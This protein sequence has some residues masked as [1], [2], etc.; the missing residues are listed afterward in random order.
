MAPG[1]LITVCGDGLRKTLWAVGLQMGLS[2]G[3]IKAYGWNGSR[4]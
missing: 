3:S 1:H 4:L 2:K